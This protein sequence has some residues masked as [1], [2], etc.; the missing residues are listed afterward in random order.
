MA[1]LL[2]LAGCASGGTAEDAAA[3]GAAATS[4]DAVMTPEASTEPTD[5]DAMMTGT[6]GDA[7]MAAIIDGADFDPASLAGTDT[8][9]WFWAPWCPTCQRQ[10]GL[11]NEALPQLPDG[12]EFIGVAGL[13]DSEDQVDQFIDEYGVQDMTHVVD[14][15]GDT[16]RYFEVASQSTFVFLDDSGMVTVTGAGTTVEEIVTRAE[17]LAAS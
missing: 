10:A 15:E 12:V 1:G 11:V 8:V 16:W 2:V 6:D 14:L 5:D 9:L 17:E 4:E 7:A 13:T 3:P